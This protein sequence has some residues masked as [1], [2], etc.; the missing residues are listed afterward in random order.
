ML[1]LSVTQWETISDCSTVRSSLTQ[2]KL[3]NKCRICVRVDS[4]EARNWPI[5]KGKYK[6]VMKSDIRPG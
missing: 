1:Q 2:V 6:V 4:V 5:P 3:E